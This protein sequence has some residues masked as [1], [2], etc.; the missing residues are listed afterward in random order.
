[1]SSLLALLCILLILVLV[2][3]VLARAAS[4]G[5]KKDPQTA[6]SSKGW[7]VWILYFA[8][9]LLI[10]IWTL[11]GALFFLS[12]VWILRQDPKPYSKEI[13]LPT[14]TEKKTARLLYTWLMLSSF[15]TVT[16]F[17]LALFMLSS[18][19]SPNQRVLAAL[20]PLI[21][22]TPLLFGLSSKSAFVF[23]HTQQ[24]IFLMAIRAGLA[25]L[26]VSIASEPF[27][28]IWLFLLGNGALWLIGSLSG[29]DQ[30]RRGE[31]WLMRRKG[32]KVISAE[33]PKTDSPRMDQ[34]LEDILKSLDAKD[35]FT[36]KNK[37]LQSFRAGNP[38]TK[39]RAVEVLS[40]LG[41]VETF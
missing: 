16:V 41:E 40:K 11:W 2:V 25:S 21:F 17:V 8:I 23:R 33:A 31:C 36:A 15:L 18:P 10:A 27:A 35:V 22:H 34:E 9:A 38:E 28:G 29:W 3:V 24:A 39:K 12:M 20:I 1:M 19:S 30:V 7:Q 26:S 5:K 14:D 37:A 4:S 32:Q 13:P 6:S